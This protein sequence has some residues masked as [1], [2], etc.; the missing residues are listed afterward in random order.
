MPITHSDDQDRNHAKNPAD[1][2]KPEISGFKTHTLKGELSCN[3]LFPIYLLNYGHISHC[4]KHES[5]TSHIHFWKSTTWRSHMEWNMKGSTNVKRCVYMNEWD[6]RRSLRSNLVDLFDGRTTS[7]VRSAPW[8]TTRHPWNNQ[9]QQKSNFTT[10]AP[11]SNDKLPLT[12]K[13]SSPTW[14]AHGCSII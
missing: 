13:D 1:K 8:C 2:P 6:Q 7:V 10:L 14:K 11:R 4:D 3:T 5:I 9:I 12:Y